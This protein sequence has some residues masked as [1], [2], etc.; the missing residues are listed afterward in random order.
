MLEPLSNETLP[1]ARRRWVDVWKGTHVET[2]LPRWHQSLFSAFSSLQ[3]FARY[4]LWR[5]E[6]LISTGKIRG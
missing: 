3:S 1:L 2:M 5:S 4:T 6:E